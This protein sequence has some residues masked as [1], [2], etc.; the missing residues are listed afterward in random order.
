[1]KEYRTYI[2]FVIDRCASTLSKN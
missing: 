2:L 1:M